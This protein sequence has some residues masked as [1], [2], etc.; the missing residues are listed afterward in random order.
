MLY[1]KR[2]EK[3][4]VKLYIGQVGR[5]GQNRKYIV[6]VIKVLL[7]IIFSGLFTKCLH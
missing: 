3:S 5:V 2:I 6:L 1:Q 4:D 7:R